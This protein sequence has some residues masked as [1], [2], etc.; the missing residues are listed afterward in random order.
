MNKQP[1]HNK[2]NDT[3]VRTVEKKYG[4]SLRY[5]SDQ[6]MHQTLKNEDVPSLSN[7]LKLFHQ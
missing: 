3:I 2:K 7:L 6:E 4:V 5:K 1:A